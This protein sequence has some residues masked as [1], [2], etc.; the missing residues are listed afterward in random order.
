MGWR[1]ETKITPE[2]CR[3]NAKAMRAMARSTEHDLETRKKLEDIA[4]AW[5]DLC[6]ELEGRSSFVLLP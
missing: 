6:E 2:W 3:S 5:E 4:A 1:D